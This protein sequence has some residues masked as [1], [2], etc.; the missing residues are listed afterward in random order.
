MYI[1]KLA[2]HYVTQ[3]NHWRTIIMGNRW[4]NASFATNCQPECFANRTRPISVGPVM[5]RFTLLIFWWLAMFGSFSAMSVDLQPNGRPPEWVH[6]QH[7]LSVRS[8]SQLESISRMRMITK[9]FLPHPLCKQLPLL[10]QPVKG[11]VVMPMDNIVELK[12]GSSQKGLLWRAL[13]LVWI[14]QKK[15]SWLLVS[16]NM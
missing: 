14:G 13:T 7:S 6:A 10:H 12:K 1:Q 4:R 3:L 2:N 5:P 15:I 16:N 9:W 11:K 8:V